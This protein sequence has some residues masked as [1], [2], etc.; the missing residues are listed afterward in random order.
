MAF[1][2]RLITMTLT[3]NAQDQ[4]AKIREQATLFGFD[5]VGF[6][7]ADLP[8]QHSARLKTY[9]ELGRHGEMS[10]MTDRQAERAQPTALWR[11]AKSV[12]M[13]GVNYGPDENPLEKLTRQDT[14]NV[15][16]YALN[17]DY[18][19]VIKKNLKKLA[20]W[21]IEN[22]GGDVK[23]FVDTA[24]VMEKPIAMKAGLGWQG[25]HTNLVS[26]EYGSWLF[27]G[28]IFTT[29]DLPPDTQGKDH[30]G[31]CH[32]CLDICPT[33]AFPA[34]YQLDARKCISY[35]TIEHKG[36]IPSHYRKAIGNRIYGCDDCLAV[37][38]WNKFANT[39]SEIKFHARESLKEPALADLAILS[40]T[41]FRAMFSKSPVKRIGRARFI[42]NVLIAIGNS[43]N[44]TYVPILTKLLDDES[45]V[46]RG[47]AVWA[48]HEIAPQEIPSY[49]QHHQHSEK[50]DTVLSEWRAA[51]DLT[52]Q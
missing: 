47:S 40:D 36:P 34:P 26:R 13:L 32:L 8:P 52:K 10:W 27:L 46:V 6:T 23:V 38:P 16:V 9:I 11:D 31:E 20:R 45:A 49:W 35:L 51:L 19:E 7:S 17:N 39:T 41:D 24:P 12:I 5:A 21:M 37:C 4:I 29:L 50:D 22:W 42:R 1:L 30:C 14:G 18:H 2:H 48:L 15:S 33:D 3:S 44:N 28:S 25:K 43:A